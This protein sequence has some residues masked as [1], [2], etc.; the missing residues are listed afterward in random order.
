MIW[1]NRSTNPLSGVVPHRV[2]QTDLSVLHYC[3]A[4]RLAIVPAA[5]PQQTLARPYSNLALASATFAPVAETYLPIV[6]LGIQLHDRRC[7]NCDW[8]DA[9]GLRVYVLW[10]ALPMVWFEPSGAT[11]GPALQLLA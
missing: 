8:L 6:M 2:D 10:S 11:C 9:S 5:Q 7:L 4:R 3:N 1:A